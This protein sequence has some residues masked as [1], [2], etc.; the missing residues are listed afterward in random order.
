MYISQTSI[1]YISDVKILTLYMYMYDHNYN[2]QFCF[3]TNCS[4]KVNHKRN[5]SYLKIE[6]ILLKLI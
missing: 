6:W 3:K 1:L 2:I 5:Y 4:L